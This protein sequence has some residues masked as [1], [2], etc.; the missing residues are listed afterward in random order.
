MSIN[1][2]ATVSDVEQ[3]TFEFVKTFRAMRISAFL[4]HEAKEFFVVR[5][6][7]GRLSRLKVSI[8]IK[9]L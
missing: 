8:I 7:E 6:C 9:I 4:P 1:H 3:T 5:Q 2:S